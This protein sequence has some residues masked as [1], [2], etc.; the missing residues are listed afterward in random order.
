MKT[1]KQHESRLESIRLYIKREREDYSLYSPEMIDEYDQFAQE[2]LET[3]QEL[4]KQT[5]RTN[6]LIYK[7]RKKDRSDIPIIQEDFVNVG[8]LD[9]DEEIVFNE[10]SSEFF[11]LNDRFSLTFY[12]KEN[13]EFV[14]FY[15]KSLVLEVIQ[16]PSQFS[17]KDFCAVG[18]IADNN[19][20][21][22]DRIIE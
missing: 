18:F 14:P 4:E 21:P 1:Y 10:V 12:V 8:Y 2:M 9:I 20:I 5:K 13:R 15:P 3:I 16:S 22:Y 17:D 7:K 6:K 11:Y 19:Y